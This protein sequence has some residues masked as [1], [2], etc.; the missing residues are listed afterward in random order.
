MA[1]V[2]WRSVAR[3]TTCS[4]SWRRSRARRCVRC[5]RDGSTHARPKPLPLPP[6]TL[7]PRPAL[8]ELLLRL[9]PLRPALPPA[10]P[11]PPVGATHSQAP[12]LDR[13]TNRPIPHSPRGTNKPPL[14][15]VAREL[16]AKQALAT[17]QAHLSQAQRLDASWERS[18]RRRPPR[19]SRRKRK[20]RKASSDTRLVLLKS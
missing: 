13:A 16:P 15:N 4:M 19:K 3:R 1:V 14:Q 6:L 7:A 17:E 11:A 20:R 2:K 5:S 12:P 9:A 10:P 18:L 8:L